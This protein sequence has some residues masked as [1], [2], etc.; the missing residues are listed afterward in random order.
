MNYDTKVLLIDD[1]FAVCEALKRVLTSEDFQVLTTN[2][3]QEA[4]LICEKDEI[5]VVLLDLNLGNEDGWKLFELLKELRPDLPIIVISAHA[6]RLTDSH[7]HR[8]S[9]VLEKPFDVSTLLALLERT[10]PSEG[11]RVA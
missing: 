2:G 7:S 9:G 10:A 1:D 6:D 5:D 3:S 11:Q 4:L 8:A